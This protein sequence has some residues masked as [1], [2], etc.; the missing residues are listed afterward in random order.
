MSIAVVEVS[1]V[2]HGPDAGSHDLD[3]SGVVLEGDLQFETAV[4]RAEE[5]LADLQTAENAPLGNS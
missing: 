2:G 3:R 5:R 4:L 1:W